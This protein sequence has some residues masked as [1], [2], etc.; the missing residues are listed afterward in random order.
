MFAAR[1]LDQ[2]IFPA[3]ELL[4]D[5]YETNLQGTEYSALAVTA[6]AAV[7]QLLACFG[8]VGIVSYAVSQHTKEIGIRMALGGRPRHILS[9]VLNQLSIPV[10]VGLIA[11]VS[12]AAGFSWCLRGRLF[13]VSSLDPAAWVL[14]VA[15]FMAT[16]GIAALLP[17]RRALRIDPLRALRHE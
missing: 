15:A 7:A 1:G 5:A 12:G 6:M 17:A 11:G 4:S 3:V 13:G 10:V 14:A 9:I 2:N 16:I 8:I